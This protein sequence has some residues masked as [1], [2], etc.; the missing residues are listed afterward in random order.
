MITI[1]SRIKELRKLLRLSQEEFSKRI[2][3][4]RSN[5]ANIEKG[6]VMLTDRVKNSII[7]E[8]NVNEV[9]FETGKGDVFVDTTDILIESLAKNHHLDEIDKKTIRNFLKL[10]D[11]KRKQVLGYVDRLLNE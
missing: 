4:S 1:H 6:N 3:I 11:E 10:S 2:D 8:F 9:W 5:L 7:R